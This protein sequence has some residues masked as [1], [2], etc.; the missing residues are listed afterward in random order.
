MPRLVDDRLS[1]LR[2]EL[3]ALRALV[4]ELQQDNSNLRDALE[5][6]S[7][8]LQAPEEYRQQYQR[9][10]QWPVRWSGPTPVGDVVHL[11]CPF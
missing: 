1:I 2:A 7:R 11:P 9:D 6:S 4:T 3:D 10:F 5:D 8:V